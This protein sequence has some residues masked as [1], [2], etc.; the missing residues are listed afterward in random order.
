MKRWM[1]LGA[2]K[3]SLAFQ[4]VQ[5]SAVCFPL[6]PVTVY[7]T[8]ITRCPLQGRLFSTSSGQLLLG[9]S[10]RRLQMCLQLCILA[11]IISFLSDML[12]PYTPA[13]VSGIY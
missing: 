12:L 1:F 7:L 5:Y 11:E 13:L 4:I 8:L 9:Y 3:E 2:Q 6:P 10:E